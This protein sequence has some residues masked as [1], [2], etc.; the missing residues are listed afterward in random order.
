[1][2]LKSVAAQRVLANPWNFPI[3]LDGMKKNLVTDYYRVQAAQFKEAFIASKEGLQQQEFIY[4]SAD[5]QARARIIV[6]KEGFFAGYALNGERV[7]ARVD[8]MLTFPFYGGWR[9]WFSCPECHRR[10][11]VL[12]FAGKVACR[13]CLDL[14]YPCQRATRGS[15]GLALLQRWRSKIN[16]GGA[17]PRYMHLSTY[18]DY[19]DR[20]SDRENASLLQLFGGLQGLKRFLQRG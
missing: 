9:L 13:R 11:G 3:D 4:N 20:I 10:S 18:N 2:P 14:L 6:Y 19:L 17:R 5:G 12:Y 15:K 16:D 8:F 7:F 1:M